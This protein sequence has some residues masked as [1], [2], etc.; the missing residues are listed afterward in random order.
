[1]DE[2]KLNMDNWAV[3]TV[4]NAFRVVRL[5]DK[6]LAESLLA[7]VLIRFDDSFALEA[8]LEIAPNGA[9]R[10]QAF[11]LPFPLTL[12]PTPG[13]MRID[14]IRFISDMQKDDQ[15]TYKDLVQRAMSQRV[16]MRARRAGLLLGGVDA[17]RT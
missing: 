17:R 12:H 8:P 1:M 5:M 16:E 11:V 2:T 7:G 3:V 10:Q 4:G 13:I 6:N 15:D 14:E 9:V